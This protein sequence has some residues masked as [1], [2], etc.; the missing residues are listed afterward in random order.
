MQLTVNSSA[1]DD[2]SSSSSEN[3]ESD[4]DQSKFNENNDILEEDEDDTDVEPPVFDSSKENEYKV[5]YKQSFEEVVSLDN[6]YILNLD[7]HKRGQ[8]LRIATALSNFT[9]KLYDFDAGNKTAGDCLEHEEKIVDVK[10][11]T[12]NSDLSS[13]VYTGSEDGTIKLWDLR[14]REKCVSIFKDD[15]DSTLKP[16]SCFDVSC[17]GRFLVAGTDV[18]KNDAFLLFWDVRTTNLLGGYWDSHQEDITQVKF[19]PDEEKTVISGSTDGIINL[20]DVTQT[21]EKDALQ[22]SFNTNSSVSSLKWLKNENQDSVISCITHTEDLQLWYTTGSSPYIIISRD[23][24]SNSMN[25]KPDVFS[26]VISCHQTD[27]NGNMML[28]VG[29]NHGKGEH[30]QSL[31][32]NNSELS[33]RTLFK[34]NKQI[35]RCSWYSSDDGIMITGG[36]AGILNVWIPSDENDT[37]AMTKKCSLKNMSKVSL[38]N[39]KS[40]PY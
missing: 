12:N 27:N 29:N 36:E 22:L 19:H 38:K 35:I 28:L 17:N 3:E 1:D 5:Q 24:I 34:N 6:V 31:E 21:T 10:F 37:S 14:L 4:S 16:L 33:P 32:I 39:R 15:S 2:T 25:I 30:L 8:S 26:Q 11:G 18:L 40:K 13:I 9:C 20:F 7:A 23:T